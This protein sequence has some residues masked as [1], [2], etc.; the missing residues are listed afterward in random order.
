MGQAERTI[1]TLE[2]MLRACVINFRD[3]WDDHL[4]LIELAYNNSYNS[5]IQMAPYKAL[6]ERKYRSPIGWFDAGETKY[7]SRV[8]PVDDFMVTEQLTYEEAPITILDRQ[9]RRL[10]TKDVASVKVLWRNKNVDEM[11]WESEED[12]KFRGVFGMKENIFQFSLVW[13]A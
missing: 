1:H 12:M 9:V 8:I 13:L 6:Y 7:P 3:N 2:D 10:R 11:T 4:L 5:S